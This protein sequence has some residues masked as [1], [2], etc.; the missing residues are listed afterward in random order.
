MK[1]TLSPIGRWRGGP[2]GVICRHLLHTSPAEKHLSSLAK[3]PL[4]GRLV[5]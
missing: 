2:I 4:V 5:L 1:G 3:R